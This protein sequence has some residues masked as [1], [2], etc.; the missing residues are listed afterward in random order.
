MKRVLWFFG[1]IILLIPCYIYS[2]DIYS[3]Q[4]VASISLMPVYESWSINDSSGFSEFSNII[5][6]GYNPLKNTSFGL[7]TRYASVSADIGSLNNSLSGLSDL[8]LIVKHRLPDENLIFNGGIN[9]PS[10]KTKLNPEEFIISQTISQEL[11]SLHTPNFG[12]GLNA[13]LG[14]TW[15]HP[16]SD[17]VVI[18]AGIS[19][20]IKSEYQPLADLSEKYTPSNE[21]SVTGGLDIKMSE[22]QTIT[23]NLTGIF[24]GSDKLDGNEIFS[25]GNRIIFNSRYRQYFNFN[26]LTIYLLYRN[27]GIAQL[28]GEY[29]VL[30]NE[31]ITPNQVYIGASFNQRFNSGFSLGYGIFTSIYEKTAGYF[32]G[33]TLYGASLSPQFTISQS[34]SIPVFLKYAFGSAKDKTDLTNFEVSAGIKFNL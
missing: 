5:S 2:Q 7:V 32:S 33:Y 18:G 12:Q 27:V 25:S 3:E 21:I 6:L 28:K 19:Y 15:F 9:I 24:Y 26:I 20:Q 34:F 22:T 14:A 11:F 10:G 23:G 4:P 16:L 30:D 1:L 17:N 29:A 31:K 13:F 8:Q